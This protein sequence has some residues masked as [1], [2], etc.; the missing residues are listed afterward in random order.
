ML[1]HDTDEHL[2]NLAHEID[3]LVEC[4]DQ[5]AFRQL[6]LGADLSHGGAARP[7]TGGTIEVG[8]VPLRDGQSFA[9]LLTQDRVLNVLNTA[10]GENE[11]IGQDEAIAVAKL[12]VE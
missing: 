7:G 5:V 2:P 8:I 9:A 4:H 10:A 3:R 6:N 12:T 1:G 11:S